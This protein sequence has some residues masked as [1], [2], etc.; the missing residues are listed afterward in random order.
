MKDEIKSLKRAIDDGIEGKS[1]WVPIGFSKMGES[2][3]I[4]QRIYTIIGGMSGT[5]KTA[6]TDL[7]YV[8]QP[9]SWMK[10]NGEENNIQVRW[11]YF[12]M[13]RSKVYKLAKWAS[14]RLYTKYNILIDVPT[15][16]GWGNRKNHIS[17]EL[18]EKISETYNVL[19]EML[20]YV[21]IM[22]GGINPTGMYKAVNKYALAHGNIIENSYMT[23]DGVEKIKKIYKPNNDR[24]VT[25]IV[26]DHIGKSKGETIEGTFYHPQTKPLLDKV[27]DYCGSEFRDFYGFS[28]VVVSQF[29]RGLEDTTRRTKT[30]MSPLPS[31]FKSTGNL[32]EDA[33]VALAL[34][35]PYKLGDNNNLG[36][37][38]QNFV[39]SAGYNRFRSC[40]VLKNSYGVDD[41]AYG[42]N[43]IGE[44]GMM[45]E[46]PRADLISNY[47]QYAEIDAIKIK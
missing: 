10:G 16:L 33:D 11:L 6:F 14:I 39:N 8:L 42:Y 45:K 1:V 25:V 18:Y 12:S 5:G 22:D 47:N 46:L 2:V 37:N 41:I 27:S 7:A 40:Y 29:N 36:Y 17:S 23:K 43:F 24:L 15:L 3:G 28:P 35:N 31:D 13:E 32:Y 34:Y 44:I 21:E 19:D 30:E 4:G 20:D 9:Y 26:I 38:V